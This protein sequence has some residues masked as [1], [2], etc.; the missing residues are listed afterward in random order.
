[1]ESLSYSSLTFH[2][3]S[4]SFKNLV[5][6]RRCVEVEAEDSLILHKWFQ[7]LIK[8]SLVSELDGLYNLLAGLEKWIWAWLEAFAVVV[9]GK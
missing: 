7:N 3:G 1:M 4:E 9:N 5:L 6:E 2:K 8:R